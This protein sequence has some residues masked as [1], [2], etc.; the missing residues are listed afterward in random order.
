VVNASKALLGK[1]LSLL[2]VYPQSVTDDVVDEDL[3]R[4]RA[5]DKWGE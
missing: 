2:G 1:V 3:A 4:I 5:G